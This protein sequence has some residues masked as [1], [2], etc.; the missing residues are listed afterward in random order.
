VPNSALQ[1][2]LE[3][4]R[5]VVPD[6]EEDAKRSAAHGAM[7]AACAAVK[8]F[9]VQ[10]FGSRAS[11]LELWDSDIDLVVLGVVKPSGENHSEHRLL[12]W[13]CWQLSTPSLTIT[14]HNAEDF[15]TFAASSPSVKLVVQETYWLQ[16]MAAV[17]LC[18]LL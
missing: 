7:Q 14:V 15:S 17:C 9:T 11:G 2:I 13:L 4:C 5:R 6:A 1:E 18:S 3:L 12:T 10:P 8:L 16:A